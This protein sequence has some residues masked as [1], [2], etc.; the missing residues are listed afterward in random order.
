MAATARPLD[1]TARRDVVALRCAVWA[2]ALTVVGAVVSPPICNLGAVLLLIAL[3]AAPSA[4]A[5]LAAAMRQPLGMAA[6]ALGIFLVLSLAWTE[7]PWSEA[8]RG[9]MQ[10][11]TLLILLFC[12]AVFDLAERR[13][14]LAR[15][16]LGFAALVLVA[17]V[18]LQLAGRSIDGERSAGILLRNEATQALF[19]AVAAAIAAWLAREQRGWRRGALLVLA[20]VLA[21]NVVFAGASRSGYV[22]VGVLALGLAVGLSSVRARAAALLAL[23]AAAVLV[24]LTS[25]IAQQR[26][27][28]GLSQVREVARSDHATS[29]GVRLVF[30]KN[31]VELAAARPIA[32]HGVGAFSAAYARHVGALPKSD[33]RG[34][35]TSDPHNQYLLI[36]VSGGVVGLALFLALLGAC[37]RQ[38]ASGWSRGLGLSCAAA[39]AATSLFNSHFSVFNESHV[40]AV[41]LGAFLAAPGTTRS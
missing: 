23:A 24:A 26:V 8:V 6:A 3:V 33:W 20:L 37:F 19:F 9:L 4:P 16:L 39:W 1:R 34:V 13:L 18:A 41:L 12:L 11:R 21:A 32:G 40:I 36:A 28:E 2:A 38:Q 14:A 22:A 25:D 35:A 17:A 30:W 7:A 29:M 15:L 10:W 31:S 27:N 5:R